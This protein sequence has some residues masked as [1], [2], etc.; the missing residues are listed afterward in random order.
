[1]TE[2][3]TTLDHPLPDPA[4]ARERILNAAYDL[5][6]RHGLQAVGINAVVEHSGVAKRTL[7]R[8]FASK[9]D[10]IVAFLGLREERWTKEWLQKAVEERAFDPEE[11]LLAIFDVFHEW[12]QDDELEGCSFINVLLEVDNRGSPVR[13]ATVQHLATVRSYLEGLATEAG[14]ER[15]DDFARRW[16]ILMKGSIIAAQEGDREAAHRAQEIGRVVLARERD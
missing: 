2:T 9:D 8:H 10:L 11:R 13:Q 4:S 1:M 16:H 3:T 7:Y 15:P 6:S 5:F 12:F 14:I